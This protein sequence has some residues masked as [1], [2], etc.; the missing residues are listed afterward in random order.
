MGKCARCGKPAIRA[1][2]GW[3]HASLTDAIACTVPHGPMTVVNAQEP[4]FEVPSG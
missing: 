4:L 2:H 1:A 3:R